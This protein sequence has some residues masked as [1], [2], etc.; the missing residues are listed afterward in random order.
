[1][2]RKH[3]YGHG[4]F[5]LENEQT[6]WTF[7]PHK[8]SLTSFILLDV[9][10]SH[11]DQASVFNYLYVAEYIIMFFFRFNELLPLSSKFHSVRTCDTIINR[12][13]ELQTGS[14]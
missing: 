3:E 14:N 1:M 13:F 10:L 5:L 4:L 6:S 9:E 2:E 11:I 12:N 7:C 8:I